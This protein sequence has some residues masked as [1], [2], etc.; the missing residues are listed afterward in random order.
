MTWCCRVTNACGGSVRS[1]G[2]WGPSCAPRASRLHPGKSRRLTAAQQQS[3]LGLVVNERPRVS[4]RDVDHLRAVLH[5]AARAGPDVANRAGH[6]DFR[7]H[8]LGRISRVAESDPARGAR[9]H[10]DFARIAWS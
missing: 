4:R 1:N 2:R 6:P 3:V 5:D 8:L 9:L 10:D 7:A